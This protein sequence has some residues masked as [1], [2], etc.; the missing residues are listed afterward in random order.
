MCDEF[1]VSRFVFVSTDKAVRP[2]NLMGA[3]KR[4]SERLIETISHRSN[5]IYSSVRFGNVLQSSGSVIPK[6]KQQIQTGGPLTVTHKEMT[7]YFMTI[8]EAAS[9]VMHASILPKKYSTY[10]LKMGSPAKDL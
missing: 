1:N 5:T 6:F 10:L 8:N 9:L 4:I 7:R 3:T 2:T